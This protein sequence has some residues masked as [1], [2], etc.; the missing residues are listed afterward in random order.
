MRIVFGHA[1]C[2]ENA[3][4]NIE[5]PPN[6][7]PV[8]DCMRFISGQMAGPW[9]LEISLNLLEYEREIRNAEFRGYKVL[10]VINYFESKTFLMALW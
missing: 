4:H 10:P 7:K 2:N 9:K 1:Q 3:R 8:I 5:L 6:L